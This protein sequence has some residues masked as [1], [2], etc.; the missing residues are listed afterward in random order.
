MF[1]WR[2]SVVILVI[3]LY[4]HLIWLHIP[5]DRDL[6]EGKWIGHQWIVIAA[7][8]RDFAFGRTVVS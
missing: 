1:L 8:L 2:C 5:Y 4:V 3:R 6:I 7:N